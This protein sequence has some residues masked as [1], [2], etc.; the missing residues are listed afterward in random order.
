MAASILSR[1]GIK[2]VADIAF[3]ALDGN[4]KPTNPVLYIDSAKVSTI[5]QTAENTSAKGGKGNAELISWD[6]GKEITVTLTDALYSPKSMAIM[7]G[8]GNPV[9]YDDSAMANA[10]PNSAYLMRT[11][12]FIATA[13]VTAGGAATDA[14]WSSTFIGPNGNAYSKVNPKF[15][16]AEGNNIAVTNIASGQ[17]YFCTYDMNVAGFVIEIS[18]NTFPGTYYVVGDTFA[19]SYE[20]G[21]DE[22]FQFIIPKAK[23]QAENTITMEAEGD[24]SVFNLNLRVMRPVD[25]V[26]MKLVQYNLVGDGTE[27]SAEGLKIYHNHVLNGTNS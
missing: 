4:G 3:Y 10:S 16:D 22:F 2:E 6:F 1:Y 11:E 8:N 19:R 26:M 15:Y 5:E 23:I 24:P 9:D 27:P 21:H 7:F 17:V 12:Q 18:A 20:G 14:G 13:T 25:G